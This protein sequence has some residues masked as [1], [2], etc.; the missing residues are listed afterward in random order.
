MT[1]NEFKTELARLMTQWPNVYSSDRVKVLWRAVEA[2]PAGVFSQAV[3][4]WIGG[5]RHAPLL[6]EMSEITSRHRER[7]SAKVFDLD[8]FR[9]PDCSYCRDTGVFLCSNKNKGPG[10]WAFRCACKRGL[11][12]PRRSI[13]Y[14]KQGH[15]DQGFVYEDVM[16]AKERARSI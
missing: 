16:T 8:E 14:Y 13:P 9:D 6:P 7:S 5:M 2:L 10:L 4:G 3:D 1:E 11:A 12:D 15:A